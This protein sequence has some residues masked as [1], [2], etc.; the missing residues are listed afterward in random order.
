MSTGLS[1]RPTD[2]RNFFG[3]T[4]PNGLIEEMQAIHNEIAREA[5][6][7]FE[8]RNGNGGNALE[9]WLHAESKLLKPVPISIADENDHLKVTAQVLG[10]AMNELKVHVEGQELRICGKSEKKEEKGDKKSGDHETSSSFQKIC[11]SVSLPAAVKVDAAS[12]VLD[13]GVLTL[14]LPKAEPAKEIAV[15]AA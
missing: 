10:F 4:F 12:A 1:I 14:T 11:C 2:N 7:L 8:W 9:D 6:G 3:M 13:Q 5:F 15:K